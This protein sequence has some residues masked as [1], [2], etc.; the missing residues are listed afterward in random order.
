MSSSL[1]SVP[2]AR[3]P[4]PDAVLHPRTAQLPKLLEVSRVKHTKWVTNKSCWV[5]RCKLDVFFSSKFY[6][7]MKCT[8]VQHKH[9]FMVSFTILNMSKVLAYRKQPY[10]SNSS[11][12]NTN[13]I[14]RLCISH[15]VIITTLTMF[16]I[17]IPVK[18]KHLINLLF[19]RAGHFFQVFMK[20]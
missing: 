16:L 18:T 12:I 11:M 8:G 15:T 14:V 6:S 1:C 4:S 3:R 5:N 19:Q 9:W 13:T 20:S 17:K 2:L 7:H 10:K